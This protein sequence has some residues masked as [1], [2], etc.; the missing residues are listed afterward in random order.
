MRL[1][2]YHKTS[3]RPMSL[4]HRVSLGFT[5]DLSLFIFFCSLSGFHIYLFK[6][7]KTIRLCNSPIYSLTR[8]RVVLVSELVVGPTMSFTPGTK[9][10]FRRRKG[11][12]DKI[13]TRSFTGITLGIEIQ[14][15][16]S[17]YFVY[18]QIGLMVAWFARN[19]SI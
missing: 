14:Y 6:L 8:V 2:C 16:C 17:S 5:F 7:I 4:T 1:E 12:I 9:C 19:L 18:I 13:K 11:S 15:K 10:G 3:T